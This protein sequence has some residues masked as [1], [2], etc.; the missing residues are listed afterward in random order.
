MIFCNLSRLRF[1]KL[2]EIAERNKENNLVILGIRSAS[3]PS[4]ASTPDLPSGDWTTNTL[5]LKALA[6]IGVAGYRLMSW[7]SI[8]KHA[9]F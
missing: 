7:H 2:P 4:S 8:G 6:H 5:F 9:G 3:A 1:K